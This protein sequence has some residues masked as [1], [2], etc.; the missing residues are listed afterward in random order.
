MNVNE[1]R[2]AMKRHALDEAAVLRV[3][4][5]CHLPDDMPVF[6]LAVEDLERKYADMSATCGKLLTSIGR[7]KT[8][9]A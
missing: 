9:G 7:A 6:K 4:N 3:I 2:L 8:C 1:F 5:T